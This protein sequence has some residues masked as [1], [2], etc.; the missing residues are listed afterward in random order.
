[1]TTGLRG[2]ANRS[3]ADVGLINPEK[4]ADNVLCRAGVI[5]NQGYMWIPQSKAK[6]I[7]AKTL[8]GTCLIWDSNWKIWG[9]WGTGPEFVLV[10]AVE[11]GRDYAVN[12]DAAGNITLTAQLM[13]SDP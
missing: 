6:A 4:P 7:Q 1:M 10:P 5:S 12:V 8:K 13:D 9:Q 11:N 2:I 3:R